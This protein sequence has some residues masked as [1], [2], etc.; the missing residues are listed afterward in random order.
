MKID[1]ELKTMTVFSSGVNF[2]DGTV[3]YYYCL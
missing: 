2:L 3:D 1:G